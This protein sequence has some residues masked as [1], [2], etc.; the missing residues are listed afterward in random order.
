MDGH[1]PEAISITLD[2]LDTSESSPSSVLRHHPDWAVGGGGAVRAR[3][4]HHC[5]SSVGAIAVWQPYLQIPNG[6]RNR[7]MPY[8]LVCEV[9]GAWRCW[10]WGRWFWVV[11]TGIPVLLLLV[12]AVVVLVVL[13]EEDNARD[14]A[15]IPLVLLVMLVIV[16]S[17]RRRLSA[18]IITTLPPLS[19]TAGP[20]IPNCGPQIL[21]RNVHH[22]MVRVVCV[23]AALV[24]RQKGTHRKVTPAPVLLLR[25]PSWFGL[26]APPLASSAG[27]SPY[28]KWS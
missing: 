28:F 4:C 19:P 23:D 18:S 12:V 11:A 27:S 22:L 26:A 8:P 16:G 10:R 21:G 5:C 14:G 20:Y 9:W 24:V 3:R 2:W 7:A 6:N 1:N 17:T 15:A 13:E 25:Q